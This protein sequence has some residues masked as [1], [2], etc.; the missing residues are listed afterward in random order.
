VSPQ[1]SERKE[2][3]VTALIDVMTE[4]AGE[5]SSPYRPPSEAGPAMKCNLSNECLEGPYA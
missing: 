3:S 1:E 5:F 2:V 4:F